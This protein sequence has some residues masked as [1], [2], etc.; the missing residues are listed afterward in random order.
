MKYLVYLA[1]IATTAIALLVPGSVKAQTVVNQGFPPGG[2]S[3]TTIYVPSTETTTTTTTTQI[4]PTLYP[5]NNSI[6]TSTDRYYDNGSTSHRYQH[7]RKPTVIFQQQNIY[8]NSIQSSCTTSVVGSPIPSPI[9]F[10]R[11]TGQPCR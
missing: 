4:S 6:T 5:S 9:P 3:S 2:Y 1:A 11:A 10:D 8:S 7:N